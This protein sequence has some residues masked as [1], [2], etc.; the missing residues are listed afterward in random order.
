MPKGKTLHWAGATLGKK[1][2]G[3]VPGAKY[4]WPKNLLGWHGIGPCIV[5]IATSVRIDLVIADGILAIE[6]NDP[7]L[8]RVRKLNRVVRKR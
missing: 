3:A 8:G 1:M 5:N 2:F 6:A 7:L 4:G